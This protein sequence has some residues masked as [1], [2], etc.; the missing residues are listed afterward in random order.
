MVEGEVGEVG[1]F[2]EEGEEGGLREVG[3]VEGEGAEGREVGGLAEGGE[4]G[5]V[6]VGVAVVPFHFPFVQVEFGQ[7]GEEGE[8]F[9]Q[10][11]FEG[12]VRVVFVEERVSVHVA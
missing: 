5:G 8:E 3:A 2:G 12:A 11:G 7:V 9:R 6:R 10:A 1:E 4:G